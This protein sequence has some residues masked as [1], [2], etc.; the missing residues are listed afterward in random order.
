MIFE[1]HA[2]YEDPAFDEDREPLLTQLHNGLTETIVDVGSTL[3]SSRQCRTLADTHDFIYAAVGIHPEE[4][5][6]FGIPGRMVTEEV[7][8]RE[9]TNFYPDD[10]PHETDD[11][12]EAVLD[13]FRQMAYDDS[14]VAIGEIG[15]D[16]YW[17]SDPKAREWQRFL[18]RK[19]LELAR[20]LDL[21]VIVH[22][23]EAAEDT[24]DIM[25]EA[26]AL[27]TRA[28]IHAY[29]YSLEQAR[30]YIDMGCY[31]GVGGVV[32]FKNAKKLRKVVTEIPLERILVE[33]D[34]P[35]MAPEPFRGMR[36]DSG[37]LPYIVKRIAEIKGY[38]EYHVME[39][40]RKNGYEFYGIK[41]PG[42]RNG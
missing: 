7:D 39:T 1:S 30:Q 20:E 17:V 4:I 31:I 37:C 5:R 32:T 10:Y 23:R 34:C 6:D 26:C 21:P 18:F 3:E 9:C 12:Y 19:Q 8:G 2:H 14:V 25:Q 40:T 16:Y 33:T 13:E 36:S 41:L 42:K 22:S 28:V 29:S 38:T 15:L 24:I 11:C 35:Y 27:G